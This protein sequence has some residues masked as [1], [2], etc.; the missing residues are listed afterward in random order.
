MSP[1]PAKVET[2]TDMLPLK[3]EGEL[4]SFLGMVNYLSEFSPTTKE[5]CKPLRRMT[6]VNAV[7]TGTDHT[8]RY[9]KRPHH[10]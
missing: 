6:S 2:V 7:C 9:M 4:Q 1:D 3:T 5:V 8:K 10:W